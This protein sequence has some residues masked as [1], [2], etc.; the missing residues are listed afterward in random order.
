[1]NMCSVS[2]L[3]EYLSF[4]GSPDALSISLCVIVLVYDVL[5]KISGRGTF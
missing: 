5:F 1:M 4:A 3:D 2:R